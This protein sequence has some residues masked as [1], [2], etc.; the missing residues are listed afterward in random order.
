MLIRLKNSKCFCTRAKYFTPSRMFHHSVCGALSLQSPLDELTGE[1]EHSQDSYLSQT[2]NHD[3][4]SLPHTVVCLGCTLTDMT[5]V[6]PRRRI[7]SNALWRSTIRCVSWP[8][9]RSKEMVLISSEGSRW[10]RWDV[11]CYFSD[12]SRRVKQEMVAFSTADFL[13]HQCVLKFPYLQHIEEIKSWM[14]S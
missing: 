1:P 4:P 13:H 11:T 7:R 2:V 9:K 8:I 14:S 3:G 6:S 5:C 12:A 10:K